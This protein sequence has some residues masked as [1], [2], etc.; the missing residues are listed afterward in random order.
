M[1]KIDIKNNKT[2]WWAIGAV[3]L[4][5]IGLFVYR[6][7]EGKSLKIWNGGGEKEIDIAN[8]EDYAKFE[9]EQVAIFEG[10]YVLDFSF[11]HK[12]ENKVV[13]GVLTQSNWF[14]LFDAEENNYVT[15]YITFE[16]GRGYSAEDYI[17]E[18]FKKINPEVVVED[19]KFAGNSDIVVKHV[20]DENINTEYYVQEVKVEDGSGWL[21]IV[22]NEKYDSDEAKQ[23]AKDMIRSFEI[24]NS[25]VGEI[26][27]DNPVIKSVDEISA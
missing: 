16:G 1:K 23:D 27:A 14:K 10:E 24:I 18:V 5:L 20:V 11:L 2:F 19:V 13:Q 25:S 22:E 12:K 3:V 15:L 17:N 7:L 26:P 9:G 8:S 4:L 6:G 21:A